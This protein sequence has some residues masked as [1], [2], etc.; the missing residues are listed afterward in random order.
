M[1]PHHSW[2][3]VHGVVEGGA[4]GDLLAPY[5]VGGAVPC[6]GCW[7]GLPL[8]AFLRWGQVG[9]EGEEL[10]LGDEEACRGMEAPEKDVSH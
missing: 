3:G 10:L 5:C 2:E 6:G 4:W 8:G 1:G 9:L 7:V